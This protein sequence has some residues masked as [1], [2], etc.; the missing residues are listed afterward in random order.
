MSFADKA[1]PVVF[2]DPSLLQILAF[3]HPKTGRQLVKGRIEPGENARAV[4]CVSWRRAGIADMAIATD[5]GTW[6]SG[7]H[8]H[9][10]SLQL[11]TFKTQLPETWTHYCS[12]DGGHEFRFSGT[13]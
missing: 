11:C 13:T 8:G 1:C 3:E 9:I 6:D 12:D 4:H 5:L 7:H 10:W 2:R